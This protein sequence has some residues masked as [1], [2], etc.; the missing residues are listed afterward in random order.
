MA[1]KKTEPKPAP[2]STPKVSPLR[3]M[4]V[5]EWVEK[6]APGWQKVV[7][8]RLIDLV[9]RAAPSATL[10]I[11]W[12]QPV[13]EHH[14]PMAFIKPAKMHVRLLAWRGVDKQAAS[15]NAAKGNPTKRA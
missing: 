10:S 8:A 14:G 3:G 6:K 12:G 15:L 4:A 1:A 13:F 7:V 2:R 11:K 5:E 9:K